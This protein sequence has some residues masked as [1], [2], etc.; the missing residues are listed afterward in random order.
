V[1]VQVIPALAHPSPK[2]GRSLGFVYP[3]DRRGLAGVGGLTFER[4]GSNN[5]QNYLRIAAGFAFHDGCRMENRI[6]LVFAS[7]SYPI[8]VQPAVRSGAC[9]S[10]VRAGDS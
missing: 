5:R 1:N 6:E 4:N 2:S 9:S 3:V 10:R 8:L 7:P